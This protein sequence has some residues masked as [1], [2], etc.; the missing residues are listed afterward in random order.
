MALASVII[1][2]AL[3]KRLSFVSFISIA[4]LGAVVY[5]AC[6]M[7]ALQLGL[8]NSYLK[9]LMAALLTLAIVSEKLGKGKKNA[10]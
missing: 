1:G 10:A 8:P 3:F 7:L 2:T 9:L 5:K 6:L 4:V